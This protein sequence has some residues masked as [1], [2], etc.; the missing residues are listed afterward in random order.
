MTLA[1]PLSEVTSKEHFIVSEHF[2]EVEALLGRPHAEAFSSHTFSAVV[3]PKE[4]WQGRTRAL[5]FSL[6][7]EVVGLVVVDRETV[8]LSPQPGPPFSRSGELAVQAGSFLDFVHKLNND[9]LPRISG[10]GKQ[11]KEFVNHVAYLVGLQIEQA[12]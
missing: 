8:G 4:M 5:P 2:G 11:R 9:A 3:T 7:P 12:T 1:H 10:F 6:S